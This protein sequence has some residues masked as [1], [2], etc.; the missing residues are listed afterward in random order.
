MPT[1][2]QLHDVELLRLEHEFQYERQRTEF[3]QQFAHSGLKT[4][5]LLNGGAVVALFTLLGNLDKPAIDKLALDETSL[6]QAFAWFIGGLVAAAAAHLL[7][8]ITQELYT[9]GHTRDAAEIYHTLS[10]KPGQPPSG[11]RYFTCGLAVTLVA[12]GAVI[13]SVTCFGI[14]A[15]AAL[16]ASK[17]SRVTTIHGETAPTKAAQLA[18]THAATTAPDVYPIST[19]HDGRT[20]NATWKVEGNKLLIFSPYGNKSEKVGDNPKDQAQ[21]LFDELIRQRH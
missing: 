19:K 5:V 1:A 18:L 16:S 7:A 9:A 10:N 11:R 4:I 8:Y 12:I 14:G 13:F 6:R 15:F 2:K 17:P 3:V 20:Y 21:L